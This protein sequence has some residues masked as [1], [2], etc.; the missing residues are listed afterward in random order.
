MAVRSRAPRRW[1]E[2]WVARG[3]ASV[4]VPLIQNWHDPSCNCGR[5]SEQEEKQRQSGLL[6]DGLERAGPSR[7]AWC[8][9][10]VEGIGGEGAVAMFGAPGQLPS[11]V[12]DRVAKRLFVVES[13]H[14]ANV[15]MVYDVMARE[16]GVWDARCA[17]VSVQRTVVHAS[18][19]CSLVTCRVPLE[20]AI[21]GACDGV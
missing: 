8:H 4:A 18:S 21:R 11:A 14:R 9:S 20:S 19:V 10:W 17:R 1:V 15:E 5:S 2:C 6:R 3:V 12:R 16:F 13:C 7:G